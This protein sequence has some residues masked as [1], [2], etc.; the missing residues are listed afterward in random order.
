MM[1][2]QPENGVSGKSSLR[3]EMQAFNSEADFGGAAAIIAATEGNH[4]AM[5][6]SGQDGGTYAMPKPDTYHFNK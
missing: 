1:K 2:N 5:L 4:P 6:I 3:Q